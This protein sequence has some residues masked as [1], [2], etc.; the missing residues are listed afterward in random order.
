M[1]KQP[2]PGTIDRE[3]DS[4]ELRDPLLRS[5]VS[6]GLL[7]H[8]LCVGFVYSANVNASRL[9]QRLAG[10]F[11]PYTQLLHLD[12]GGVRLQFTDG[13]QDSDD[14]LLLVAPKLSDGSLGE[15]EA[16]RIPDDESRLLAQ[17]R[18]LLSLNNDVAAYSAEREDLAALLAQSIGQYAMR[19]K[20]F[21]HVVVSVVHPA[22][23]SLYDDIS[24]EERSAEFTVYEA[25]VWQ[26]EDGVVHTQKRAT[27]L[28][29]A[30]TSQGTG[31]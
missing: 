31:S 9:Q 18:R 15:A 14:H 6:L 28:G 12:P 29:A 2:S 8:L 25:E 24:P 20:Q 16:V 3:N 22:V 17:R 21:D 27:G 23:Q 7:L 13:S 30:P 26:D 1:A 5:F 10:I 4:R 19:Q 11:A